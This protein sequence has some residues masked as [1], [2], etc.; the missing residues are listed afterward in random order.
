MGS[1]PFLKPRLTGPR[2]D[3][4][5]IP[6]EV[7]AD[8]A[9]LSELLLELAKW[10]WKEANPGRRR[11]PKG[12]LDGFE[13]RV[14]K[15]EPGSAIPVITLVAPSGP[16]FDRQYFE[17]ARLAVVE[18]VCAAESGGAIG[19][20]IPQQFLGY[21]DRFG[22]SLREGEAIELEDARNGKKGRL[23]R[24]SRKALVRAS[25]LPRVTEEGRLYG[26]IHEFDQRNRSF[27]IQLEN[28]S[29][30]RGI[31]V[32][33]T[34]Y[35]AILHAHSGYRTGQRVRIDGVL[36]Y[37]R[38]GDLQSVERVES[39]T[40][41]DTLDVGMRLDGLRQL[42]D[43]WLDGEGPALSPAGLD[44]LE[45]MF[46]RHYPDDCISPHLF[47]TPEG[48]VRGEWQLAPWSVSIDFDLVAK[49]ADCHALNLESDEE[50]EKVIDA[51]SDAGWAELAE[52]IRGFGGME[53]SR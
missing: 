34:H 45:Q 33:E 16:L 52:L 20:V 39:V 1:E 42:K 22:R 13:L 43:G 27:Q 6:L 7:L 51:G 4:A 18:A 29:I 12:F 14:A 19:S 40:N 36:V 3:A 38:E 53:V 46:E 35:D 44:W 21:F 15:V 50:V 10:K 23:T 28:G 8:F 49:K 2:F 30:V 31:P 47:P 24:E 9:A 11:V 41:M 48:A 37:G 5:E 25:T 26:Q 32:D 17:D